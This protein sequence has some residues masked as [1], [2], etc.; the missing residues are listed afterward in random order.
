MDMNITHLRDMFDVGE[1]QEVKT[2]AFTP[3]S[4]GPKQILPVKDIP[5]AKP[6]NDCFENVTPSNDIWDD[7]ESLN[8]VVDPRIIPEVT[9]T[10]YQVLFHI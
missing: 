6:L 7:D 10:Y 1:K 2:E 5:K 8:N 9:D 4:I 3:A